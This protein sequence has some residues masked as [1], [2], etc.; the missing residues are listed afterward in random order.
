MK[1]VL[2]YKSLDVSVEV[3]FCG[4]VNILPVVDNSLNSLS[5]ENIVE[6]WSD[7]WATSWEFSLLPFKTTPVSKLVNS[8]S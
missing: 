4:K 1:F 7:W 5:L 3:G 2:D 8:I 6:I